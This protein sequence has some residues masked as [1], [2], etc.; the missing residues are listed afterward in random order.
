[1]RLCIQSLL[2]PSLRM[3][4]RA[5]MLR[6]C[7]KVL[8]CVQD[9]PVPL[10][11]LHVPA[12]LIRQELSR[13]PTVEDSVRLFAA[14]QLK[15]VINRWWKKRINGGIQ[16][17]EKVA[18]RTSLL[19]RCSET[20]A[21]V[22]PPKPISPR[23]YFDKSQRPLARYPASI[24]LTIGIQTNSLLT[25]PRAQLFPTVLGLLQSQ[26]PQEVVHA[27]YLSHKLS[28]R[29]GT[30]ADPSGSK[31]LR[32]GSSPIKKRLSK[33]YILPPRPP[34]CRYLWTLA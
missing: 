5:Q 34:P 19:S 20:S 16:E 3:H 11:R 31:A 12:V 30:A 23:R 9:F 10:R 32:R 7:Y 21:P 24:G 17:S 27:S 8:N 25:L 4:P 13:A 2:P 15:N 18:L 6:P 22:V 1:M 14:T 28:G 26:S 29:G 33:K